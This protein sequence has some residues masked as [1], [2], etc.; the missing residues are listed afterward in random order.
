MPDQSVQSQILT[1]VKVKKLTFYDIFDRI[2]DLQNPLQAETFFAAL[3]EMYGIG[4]VIYNQ[5]NGPLPTHDNCFLEGTYPLN[6]LEHYFS[7][8]YFNSDPVAQQGLICKS[9][10]DWHDLP[11]DSPLVQQIFNE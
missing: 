7:S 6:W 3:G 10:F 4:P 9:P 11:R 2:E 5:V 1:M 8:G